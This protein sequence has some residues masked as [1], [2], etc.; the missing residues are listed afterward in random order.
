MGFAALRAALPIL[1]APHDIYA[2]LRAAEFCRRERPELQAWGAIGR[3]SPGG[4]GG[5]IFKSLVK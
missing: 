4:E 3:L 5:V 1:S 2:G